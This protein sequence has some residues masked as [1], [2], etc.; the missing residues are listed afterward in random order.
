[1]TIEQ[2]IIVILTFVIIIAV[3]Q[4]IALAEN[5]NKKKKKN[6]KKPIDKK[7]IMW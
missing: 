6:F 2:K 3:F 1:M 5:C 4:L 7:A